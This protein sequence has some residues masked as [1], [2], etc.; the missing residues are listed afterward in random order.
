M[1]AP[2]FSTFESKNRSNSKPKR[3]YTL[4][5]ANRA[6]PLV[7][8]IVRDI[9][10]AHERATQ[11]QAKIEELPAAAKDSA[12]AQDQLDSALDRLQDYVDELGTLGIELKDYETGLID[13]PGRHEGRDVFLC[14]K[15]GEEKVGHWH[16]MHAG[17]AGR[18]PA[19]KLREAE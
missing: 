3:R 12:Y 8:R 18:Q 9:V 15:L 16:E 14:W 11:L 5:E 4:A 19:S 6:L 1:P 7:T 2:Q 13:F 17:F 10:N